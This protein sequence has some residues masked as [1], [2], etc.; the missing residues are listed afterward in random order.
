MVY[1]IKM[2]VLSVRLDDDLEKKL[3]FIMKQRKIVDK[4]AYIRQLLDKSVR[5]DIVDYLCSEVEAK[6]MSSWKASE[7]TQISLR[8]F[9]SELSKRGMVNYDESAFEEDLKFA[10]GE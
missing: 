6:R 2:G 3:N 9:L 7:I 10:L 4:S 1:K 5:D 8:A